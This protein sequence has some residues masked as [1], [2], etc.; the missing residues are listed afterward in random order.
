MSVREEFLLFQIKRRNCESFVWCVLL[1]SL[2]RSELMEWNL[3]S[4]I[5]NM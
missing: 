4:Q 3:K 5:S 2:G 1:V